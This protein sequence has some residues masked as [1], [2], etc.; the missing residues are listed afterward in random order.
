MLGGEGPS[1]AAMPRGKQRTAGLLAWRP[2][3]TRCCQGSEAAGLGLKPKL[4][5]LGVG[6]GVGS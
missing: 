4:T 6:V 2:S 5:S 1:G 3:G